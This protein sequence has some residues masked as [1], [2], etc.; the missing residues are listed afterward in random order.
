LD[1]AGLLERV[2][3]DRKLLVEIISLFTEDASRLLA[4]MQDGLDRRDM[5]ILQRSAHSMK[6]AAANLSANATVDA[7]SKLEASAK[8]GDLE[9][10]RVN[11]ASLKA[12]VACLLPGLVGLCQDVSK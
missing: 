10:A 9:L 11:L 4:A 8:N 7:A 1:Q 12:A 3:G 6:G 5:K 2:E